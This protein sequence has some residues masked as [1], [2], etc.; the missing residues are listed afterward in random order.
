MFRYFE[1]LVENEVS[2]S[3]TRTITEADV[4]SFAALTGD[5]NPLHI[6]EEFARRT[7]YGQRVAHGAFVFALSIGLLQAD[8][9][10]APHILAFLG[11]ERLRFVN[12]VFLGDTIRVRQTVRSL[13]PVNAEAGLLEAATEVLNQDET[14]TVSY[15]AKFLIRRSGG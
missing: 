9:A 10:R 6:D 4:R 13:N 1:E 15:T 2:F 7:R 8:N 14:V 11:V 5:W 12:P 3:P